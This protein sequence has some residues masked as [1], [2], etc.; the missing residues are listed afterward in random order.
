M[1]LTRAL[2]SLLAL[3]SIT[4]YAGEVSA[5][6]FFNG[7]FPTGYAPPARSVRERA[8]PAPAM[9]GYQQNGPFD[10]FSPQQP[11]RPAPV[12]PRR[13]RQQPRATPADV[14]RRSA[15][16]REV[17]RRA[18]VRPAS[19]RDESEPPLNTSQSQTGV[20]AY[21]V[22]LCDGRYYPLA[23]ALSSDAATACS[24]ICPATPTKVFT[25]SEPETARA[26]DG[27]QYR[28]L[29]VA[30][31]FRERIAPD[32]SCTGQGPG[33]LVTVKLQNDPTLERGDIIVSRAGG[34]VFKGA[35]ATPYRPSDFTPVSNLA[36]VSADVRST[37][38][39]IKTEAPAS[40]SAALK[41]LIAADGDGTIQAEKKPRRRR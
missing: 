10:W 4:T 22:R 20:I 39:G 2:A 9:G 7:G 1:R 13:W 8:P 17:T 16:P 31:T 38:A 6:D 32:C 3:L 30:F 29:R 28:D 18:R 34:S 23:K 14:F 21:C 24:T 36:K 27:T 40:Q 12:A 5:Q 26:A 41:I 15:A 11:A 35:R 37:L 25:G 19:K 33:G